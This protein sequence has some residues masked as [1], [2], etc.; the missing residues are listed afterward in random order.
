MANNIHSG[1]FREPVCTPDCRCCCAGHAATG[2]LTGLYSPILL[3]KDS[4]VQTAFETLTFE[5]KDF[6]AHVTLNRPE[7]KNAMNFKMVAELYTIFTGL[8][9]RRDVRVIVLSGANGTFCS[10][11]D[12][13][14]MRDHPVPAH[15]SGVNLDKMLRACNEAAQVVIARVEGAALGGGFGL[16]CC[17]DIAIASTTAQFGL[18]EVR[19]GIAPAFISP[20]VLQRLGLTR[21][22]ALM[23]TGRRFDGTEAQR[24]GLVHQAC[25]PADLESCVQQ[26]LDDLRQCAPGAIAAIKALLFAV[27]DVPLDASVA[28]RADLLNRLRGGAEAQEGMMAFLQKRPPAWVDGGA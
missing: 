10:G 20:F 8:R 26:H 24:I 5:I 13:K 7:T 2:A 9:D 22:R 12:I 15:E 6:A 23:L 19:I 21:S 1:Y 25:P 28:Y 4:G 14:E 27:Q 16:V 11:G 3:P 17:S 18:P